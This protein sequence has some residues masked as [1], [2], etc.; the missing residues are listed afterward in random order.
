MKFPKSKISI[1][2]LIIKLKKKKYI[3]IFS[4]CLLLVILYFS[5]SGTERSTLPTFTV[6]KGDFVISITESG[7]LKAASNFTLVAPRIWGKLRIVR[8][9]NEGTT[10]KEGDMLI[11]FDQTEMMKSFNDKKNELNVQESELRKLK[12]D[13]EANMSRLE[14]DVDNARI[15]YELSKL[16]VERMKF[17]SESQQKQAQLELE[18]N[19]NNYDGSKQK[20]TSQKI[21][22]QSDLNKLF[23]KLKQIKS[24]IEKVQ[25]DMDALVVKAPL[26]GLVVYE[27]NWQTGK[28]IAIGDE[29]W[30]G[31]ALISLPDLSKV[32]VLTMVN[33]IDVSKVKPGQPVNIKLD[34]FPDKSFTGKINSIATIGKNKDDNSSVKVF[35]V[36]VD[37][38]NVDPVF[39]PGMTTSNEI[40]TEVVKNAVSVP[41]EAVFEK[42]AKVVVY[43]MDGNNP[44]PVEVKFGKKNSDFIIIESGLNS[45][46]LVSLKDPSLKDDSPADESGKKADTKKPE[47]NRPQGAVRV[48]GR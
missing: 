9:A 35:D 6:K 37:V 22:N 43:K 25:K 19:K 40:I 45:G 3:Y 31:G 12:A 42:D 18:R 32:Q 48:T 17:E 26:P 13:Q 7:E 36:V 15:T 11:Q 16:N 33:E 30:P 44:V 41:L 38:D 10:V 1:P 4:S 5:I 14:A 29:P 20:I 21:I 8:L 47:M 39:K 27:Y 24:D 46:D 34:A 23:I 28:K 2:D